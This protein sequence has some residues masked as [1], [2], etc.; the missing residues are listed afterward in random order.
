MTIADLGRRASEAVRSA[1]N[2]SVVI[3]NHGRPAGL[4]LGI[5]G[6]DQATAEAVALR[7]M[8]ERATV[9]IQSDAAAR[10]LDAMTT[11]DIDALIA[12]TRA[13]RNARRS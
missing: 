7:V 2:E 12:A 9:A 5:D 3:T 1:Q 10:G 4:L 8:A 6:L 13:D 11:D